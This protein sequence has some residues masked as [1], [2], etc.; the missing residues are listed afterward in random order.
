MAQH[1]LSELNRYTGVFTAGCLVFLISISAGLSRLHRL[2][3][4]C[5]DSFTKAHN[6]DEPDEF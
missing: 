2:I 4:E 3:D 6:L 1:D 5:H